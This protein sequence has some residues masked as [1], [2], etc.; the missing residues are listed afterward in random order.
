MRFI[1]SPAKKMVDEA[2]LPHQDLPVFIER[3]ERLR[4]WMRSLSYAEQKKL[5]VCSDA[6]AQQN[7]ER[8]AAMKA[9]AVFLNCGRGGAV[10]PKV[11]YAALTEGRIAVAGIDV[12]EP[13]PLPAD[14][15]LWGL[16]NLLITPHVAGEYHLAETFERIVDIAAYNVAACLRGEQP[17]NIV[18]FAT[19][20]KK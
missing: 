9:S 10:D 6:I 11:L 7:A 12:C 4:D 17:R 19:G 15:P 16:D 20:Y 5:W 2:A 1:I 3:T 8:F 18:D 14:S 13:E